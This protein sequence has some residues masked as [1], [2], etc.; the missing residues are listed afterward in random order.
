MLERLKRRQ[1]DT[2]KPWQTP[3]KKSKKK[4]SSVTMGPP[5]LKRYRKG[6][7]R[8]AP[9][10]ANWKKSEANESEELIVKRKNSSD[11]WLNEQSILTDSD[12]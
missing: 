2:S 6:W 8:Q 9:K 11:S 4:F 5:P 7:N 12:F 1:T 3:R 10:I